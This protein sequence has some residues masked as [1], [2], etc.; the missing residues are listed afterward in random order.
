MNEPVPQRIVVVDN[1]ASGKST[2]SAALAQRLDLVHLK[3]DT[4]AH[5]PRW[6]LSSLEACRATL[7]QHTSGGG[8]VCD[9]NYLSRTEPPRWGWGLWFPRGP[10]AAGP[11]TGGAWWDVGTGT[12]AERG[13]YLWGTSQAE[14]RRITLQ[15]E[16]LRPATVDLFARAGLAPGMRVLDVGC[17]AGDVALL[18]REVVGATGSVLGIDA[19]AE[20]VQVARDRAAAA[21]LEGVE[22]RQAAG[23]TF[24]DP[25]GFDLVAIRW[26]LHHQVDPLPMLRAAAAAVRP[27][28]VLVVDELGARPKQL[29]TPRVVLYEDVFA[30]VCEVLRRQAPNWDVGY[31]LAALFADA[32]LPEPHLSTATATGSGADCPFPEL[33]LAALVEVSPIVERLGLWRHGSLPGAAALDAVREAVVASRS[34]LTYQD[35][36][37]AWVR[38]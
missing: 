1:M 37:C 6:Q 13:G 28:G 26:V 3:L 10:D 15:A 5:G 30:T 12:G 24:T 22:F 34:Q 21:G 9:G 11:V 38:L 36:I 23:E 29:S 8:W 17:G 7:E 4:F 32:G 27:G 35:Q 20:V 2:L 31:R 19:A 25:D 14:V 16:V 18:A 33:A